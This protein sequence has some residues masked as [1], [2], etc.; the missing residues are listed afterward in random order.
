[1]T[2]EMFRTRAGIQ[3]TFIPYPGAPQGLQDVIG[4]RVSAMVEGL[5]AF[6]GAIASNLVKPL[7]VTSPQRLPNMPNL[8]TVAETIPGFNSSGWLVMLAPTGLPD[9]VV[10]K[11]DA[12]LRAVLDIPEVKERFDTTATYIRH[13]SPAETGQFI[14]SEQDAWRPI[15]KQ[16]GVVN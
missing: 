3:M 4:G 10:H 14:K 8:P 11:I 2:G 9:D 1:M 5:A 15:V 6:T 13:L 12:D 16:V 7:A